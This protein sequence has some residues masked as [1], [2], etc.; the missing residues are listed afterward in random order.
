MNRSLMQTFSLAGMRLSGLRIKGLGTLC[1]AFI[2]L[3][4]ILAPQA[5][6]QDNA[7]ISGTVAD[8]TGAMLPS[9][10]IALTNIGTGQTRETTANSVGAF[11]FGNVGVGTYTL[12]ATATGFQKFVRTGIV[13]NVAQSLEENV[14]LTVG[15]QAQTVTVEADA[16]QVQTETSEISTLISGEQV[17]QLATN[18]RNVV[19]LAALGMGVSSTLPAFGGIDALTSSNAISFNGQRQSHN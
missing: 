3:F 17:R 13:V 5:G 7:T 9:A 19:Q 14:A 10:S 11:R 12:T 18:G 4:L 8:N 1:V 2:A 15:S 16:L 6:A